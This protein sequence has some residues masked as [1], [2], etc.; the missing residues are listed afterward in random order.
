MRADRADRADYGTNRQE[1]D[2][3]QLR[4]YAT[5]ERRVKPFVAEAL[6][7]L[8]EPWMDELSRRGPREPKIRKK[9][10]PLLQALFNDNAVLRGSSKRVRQS[11]Q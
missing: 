8:Y 2:W 11:A 9:Y 4:Y 3:V 5:L 10:H 1:L 6:Y 7:N